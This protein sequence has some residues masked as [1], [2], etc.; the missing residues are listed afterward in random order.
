MTQSID[1]GL[2]RGSNLVR[3]AVAFLILTLSI[4]VQ[5]AEGLDET[6]ANVAAVGQD[7][8]FDTFIVLYKERSNERQDIQALQNHLS[9]VARPTG[10][11]IAHIRTLAIGAEL[12]HVG[13]KLDRN[14]SLA[15]MKTFL[16]NPNV[17]YIEPD[18]MLFS[19]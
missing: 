1:S 5:A 4:C 2:A 10:L 13:E 7:S 9:D 16:A 3:A 18:A 12:V 15:L 8:R 14:A 6:R 11:N 19:T 17:I